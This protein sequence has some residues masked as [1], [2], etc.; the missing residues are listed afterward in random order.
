M[1]AGP[2]RF[3][4]LIWK[5]WVSVSFKS[6]TGSSADAVDKVCQ[7]NVLAKRRPYFFQ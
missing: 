5:T 3:S 2:I 6:G 7:I 4:S 1:S